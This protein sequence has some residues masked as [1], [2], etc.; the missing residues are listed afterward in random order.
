LSAFD[1]YTSNDPIRRILEAGKPLADY[2]SNN[3]AFKRADALVAIAA[4]ERESRVILGGDVWLA[5]N[6]AFSI[7]GDSWHID[8]S[9]HESHS[10]NVRNGAAKARAFVMAYPDRGDGVP[11]FEL[12]VD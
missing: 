1:V 12:V 2:G 3:W 7:T 5:S 6:G 9:P 11:Y 10:A 8:P 4:I